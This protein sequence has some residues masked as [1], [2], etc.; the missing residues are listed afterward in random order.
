MP[1]A[2]RGRLPWRRDGLPPLQLSKS[3]LDVKPSRF[4]QTVSRRSLPDAVDV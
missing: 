2:E 3:S 1:P 4:R